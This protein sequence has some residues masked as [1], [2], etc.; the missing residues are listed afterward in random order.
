MTRFIRR[1]LAAFI[2][3]KPSLDLTGAVMLSCALLGTKLYRKHKNDARYTRSLERK[4]A[5]EESRPE[6]PS[7]ITRTVSFTLPTGELVEREVGLYLPGLVADALT[8]ARERLKATAH[9]VFKTAVKEA[10]AEHFEAEKK[11]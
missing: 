10:M 8:D 6:M 11:P 7:N 4:L 2:A 1:A 9:D 3:P 5:Q